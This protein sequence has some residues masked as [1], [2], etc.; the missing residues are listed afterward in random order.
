[1]SDN[2]ERIAVLETKME[3]VHEDNAKTLRMFRE[4]ME[5]E[6]SRWE[7]I[8]RNTARQK[9]F[10]GGVVFVISALWAAILAGLHF[11]SK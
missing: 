1:M 3:A 8:Q 11:M 9:G 4:H 6:D 7:E 10:L 2:Q 5:K